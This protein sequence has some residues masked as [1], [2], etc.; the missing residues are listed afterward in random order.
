LD[1]NLLTS[2]FVTTLADALHR[3][4]APDIEFLPQNQS[5]AL[6]PAQAG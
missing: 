2:D 1:I 3:T 6:L 4:S 5:S